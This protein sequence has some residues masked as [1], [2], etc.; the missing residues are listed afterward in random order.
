MRYELNPQSASF[1]RA[2]NADLSAS[3]GS[4][5]CV[6]FNTASAR[7]ES[8][9]EL[10]IRS[11]LWRVWRLWQRSQEGSEAQEKAC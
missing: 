6:L 3:V 4:T 5:I 1:A 2:L 10:W 8:Y 11:R 7:L 9:V